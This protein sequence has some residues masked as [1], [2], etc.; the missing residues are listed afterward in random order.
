[1]RAGPPQLEITQGVAALQ[2]GVAVRVHYDGPPNSRVEVV[3]SQRR[4]NSCP[5]VLGG[6]CLSLQDARYVGG[7]RTNADGDFDLI[8]QWDVDPFE[9]HYAQAVVLQPNNPALVSTGPTELT[10]VLF[11]ESDAD[12][13]DDATEIGAGL[14][15]FDPDSDGGGTWD[16]EELVAGTDPL[17][18]TD[19]IAVEVYCDD[20]EDGDSDGLIDCVDSDC[21][22]EDCFD[23]VDNDADG[24]VDCEDGGCVDQCVETCG[25]GVDNDGDGRVD[26]EDDECFSL[27]CHDVVVHWVSGG[28]VQIVSNGANAFLLG[29]VRGGV[30]VDGPSTGPRVCG[31]SREVY[32]YGEMFVEPGCHLD[33]IGFFSTAWF[34]NEPGGL[35]T[36]A[37]ALRFVGE[38]FEDPYYLG[39]TM[40]MELTAGEP[41]GACPGG[42][43]V[44][45]YV[46][47][48]GDGYGVSDRVDLW[49]RLGG[50]VYLCSSLPGYT[51]MGGDC[52][53]TDPT[54]SPGTVVLAPGAS[55]ADASPFDLDGD[56]VPSNVDVDDRDGTR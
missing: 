27:D 3:G 31:W 12:A 49:G 1:M 19:D 22:C 47:Q 18:P 40:R 34:T 33:H 14:N 2:V 41:F 23:G 6:T 42:E 9:D 48:D 46:D 44:R 4:G 30:F 39:S 5:T 8:L 21:A 10:R 7:G 38:R 32:A 28:N 50:T 26:C 13:I 43:P 25:D 56:G 54:W 29:G 53:D 16:H 24:L 45:A 15:P 55:C 35:R 51:L 37:G 11:A 20:D 52:D 17:D 36:S